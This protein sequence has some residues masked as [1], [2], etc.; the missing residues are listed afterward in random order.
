MYDED[1]LEKEKKRL[2][3]LYDQEHPSSAEIAFITS[4]EGYFNQEA[5][6]WYLENAK[7]V[8]TV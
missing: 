8:M 6:R 3:R 7:E 5:L 2:G 1:F 4:G